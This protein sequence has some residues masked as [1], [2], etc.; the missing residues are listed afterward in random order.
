MTDDSKVKTLHPQRNPIDE[1][2]QEI[3]RIDQ[4]TAHLRIVSLYLLEQEIRLSVGKTVDGEQSRPETVRLVGMRMD[5]ENRK[6]S[7]E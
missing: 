5:L 7:G 1:L 4:L 3:K 2:R 6:E